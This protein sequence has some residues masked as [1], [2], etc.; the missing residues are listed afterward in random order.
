MC[1]SL[2]TSERLSAEDE[3]LDD[4]RRARRGCRPGR[5]GR[6]P[7]RARPAAFGRRRSSSA[8]SSSSTT[9]CGRMPRTSSS[10]HL[11]RARPRPTGRR[12]RGDRGHPRLVSRARLDGAE[13]LVAPHPAAVVA[14]LGVVQDAAPQRRL[15]AGRVVLDR[16]GEEVVEAVEALGPVDE[17]GDGRR[18]LLVDPGRDVDEHDLAHELGRVVRRARCVVM[19]PSDMPTT[20]CASGASARIAD[21]DVLGV[22]LRR[23]AMPS[24]PPSEWPWPGR[25]M[26]TSGRSSASATVSHV[27]AFCAPPCRSTSSGSASPHTSALERAGRARPPPTP[28][29]RWAGRRRG[30][31]TPRRSRGT[32]RT[33]RTGPVPCWAPHRRPADASVGATTTTSD[34]G[35]GVSDAPEYKFVTYETLDDGRDRAD[36]AQPA[37]RAATRRTAGMLVEL[38]DAL[39]ARRGRRHRARRHPRRQRARCSRPATTWARRSAARSTSGPGPAPDAA[40]STAAPARAP[41][42]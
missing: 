5:C 25:S 9:D 19:P 41:R 16:A 1:L 3:L 23:R 35:D 26:A 31:R 18:L 30:G 29:A 4:L 24:R 20:A 40:R 42:T 38:D 33:R 32:S 21:R 13:A 14:L 7:R 28:G 8:S 22:G 17:L 36:H 11:D 39:P 2:A 27:C 6:R 12:S 15:G 10:G 37:R 34:E